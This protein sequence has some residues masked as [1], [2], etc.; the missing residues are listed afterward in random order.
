M[1]AKRHAFVVMPFG[2]K[3]DAHGN[4]IDFNA[5]FN[6]LL[7]PALAAAGLHVFRADKQLEAGEI[8]DVPGVV[9]R[10]SRRR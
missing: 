1:P 5:V 6:E 7:Q 8:R 2:T 4:P 10:R 9:D 3:P